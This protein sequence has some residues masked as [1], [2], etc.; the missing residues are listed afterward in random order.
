MSNNKAA[1]RVYLTDLKEKNEGRPLSIE[2]RQ[3]LMEHVYQKVLPSFIDECGAE[4][5]IYTN[6]GA[7]VA[8][9]YRRVLYTDYGI[10]L[11]IGKDNIHKDAL[12]QSTGNSSDEGGNVASCIIYKT[13]DGETSVRYQVRESSITPFT[14][15]CYYIDVFDISQGT[16]IP[17]EEA[18]MADMTNTFICQPVNCRGVYKDGLNGKIEEKWPFIPNEYKELCAEED[19]LSLLGSYQVIPTNE[20]ETEGVLNIFCS[21]SPD[22]GNFNTNS[23]VS[24]IYDFCTSYP[25][26]HVAIPYMIACKT[27]E[28]WNGLYQRLSCRL[29]PFHVEIVQFAEQ[30]PEP[31]IPVEVEVVPPVKEEKKRAFSENK[32]VN[33][34]FQRAEKHEE[35]PVINGEDAGTAKLELENNE[36]STQNVQESDRIAEVKE[37]IMLE[38]YRL[39]M[40]NMTLNDAQDVLRT[41]RN[42]RQMTPA[43]H[44][45]LA[46][47]SDHLA[48]R[49]IM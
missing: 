4:Q 26:F 13:M 8:D 34:I 1:F 48:P 35:A 12:Q 21:L 14:S 27:D 6:Y 3:Y 10:Y 36:L 18:S 45:V 28:E 47:S 46:K 33:R 25:D 39:C 42:L 30:N 29:K 16:L 22:E 15:G 31:E 19:A 32:M 9:G 49:K 2:M 23:M 43:Q 38:A 5:S 17:I 11:E 7:F 20:A 41:L 37:S 40:G 44:A 24:A